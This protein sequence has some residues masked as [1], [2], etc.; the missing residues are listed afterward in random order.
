MSEPAKASIWFTVCNVIQK[1]ILFLTTPL[2]T[3]MLTTEEYGQYS[4]FMSWYSII[5]I[6]TTLNLSAGVYNKA[7]VKYENKEEVTS[8]F[9]GLSYVTTGFVFI[10]YYCFRK[11]LNP[12]LGISTVYI[13]L[14]FFESIFQ[15]AFLLWS[16]RERFDYKYKKLV[17][18]TLLMAFINPGLGVIAVRL[19]ENKALARVSSYVFSDGIFG[20]ILAIVIIIK[21]KK[22]YSKIYW[23]YALKFNI[24]LIPHYLSM[25]ILYSSDRLMINNMIGS[26]QAA[27]YNIAYTLSSMMTIL[28]NAIN[29]SFIPYSYKAL[30]D[31]SYNVIG[32]VANE[33]LLVVA[34]LC[35]LTMLVGPELVLIVGGQKYYEA[36]WIMPPV[37]T[38]VFFMF[39]YPL[40]G[41]IEFYYEKT[42][43]VLVASSCGAILN[44]ILNYIFIKL[45]GYIAA[46]YT[47]LIC[48]ILF[49][50]AHYFFYKIVLKENSIETNIYN[51]KFI[52]GLSIGILTV[53][54]I[55]IIVYNFTFVRYLIIF[56]LVVILFIKRKYVW[57][58][59]SSIWNSE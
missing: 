11:W 24:P 18:V 5:S 29:N 56:V 22:F 2:F 45:F 44:I 39:L 32:R 54:A 8:S 16:V 58:K 26:S 4:V 6:F 55:M 42:N 31:K 20:I 43:Y 3:R 25:N 7:L 34:L 38:S 33:L 47:T 13:I 53:M 51:I 15:S 57:G 41:N 30:K 40:F 36:I 52:I 37:A 10:I 59:I 28:T 49:S 48:Y 21:G 14:I 9:L 23:K 1:G 19:S 12:F 17:I 50:F 46:G 27:I 35:I